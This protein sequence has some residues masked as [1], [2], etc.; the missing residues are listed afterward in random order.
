[1][2]RFYLEEPTIE[3]KEEALEFLMEFVNFNSDING[4]GGMDHCLDGDTYEEWLEESEKRK[5]RDYAYSINRVPGVP[6]F[7]VRVSDSRIVGMIHVRYSITEEM[8]KKL[9]T[10][11]GYSIRPTERRKGYNKINLYLGL[12]KAKEL[13]LK[14]VMLDCDAN[15]IGSD[16]T[17]RDLGGI[18][19]KSE[20]D[21]YDG[22]LTNVYWI[23]VE[24]SLND[25]KDL[26]KDSIINETNIKR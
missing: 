11:I 7:L 26:Y 21:P 9:Y 22:L 20:I 13:G 6:Y 5:D 23:D 19:E 16:K 2:E 1:M 12:I 14:N 4:T 8:L 10:H 15:N 3:R 24:K 25:Y 18:L 17:I